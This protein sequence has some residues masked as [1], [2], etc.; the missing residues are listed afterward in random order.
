MVIPD[1]NGIELLLDDFVKFLKRKHSYESKK[2]LND[3][4]NELVGKLL[5]IAGECLRDNLVKKLINLLSL[6]D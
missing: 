2:L 1:F 3:R 5:T 6:S 4:E